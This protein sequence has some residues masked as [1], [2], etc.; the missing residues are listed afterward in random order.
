MNS[1]QHN[2][3]GL[4]Q[5]ASSY[6]NKREYDFT[7]QKKVGK[8]GEAKIDLWLKFHG[9]DIQDV[10]EIPEYQKAGI[11]RLLIRPDGEIAKAEF[12]TDRIAKNSEQLFFETVS[13][14]HRNILG[15]GWTSQADLWIFLIPG[16]ELLFIEPGKL[17]SLVAEKLAILEKKS[18]QNKGYSSE[19]FLVPLEE[20]RKIALHVSKFRD[21]PF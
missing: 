7:T 16:Q 4:S 5:P 17:R 15:W 13:V 2:G 20:V 14:V 10:S 12:K 6:A 11:D 18:V 9:Y 8:E 3:A 21:V 1:N 19:G